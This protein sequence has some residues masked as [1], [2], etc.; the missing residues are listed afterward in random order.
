MKSRRIFK[1][2]N[3]FFQYVYDI[4]KLNILFLLYVFRGLVLFGLFP[5]FVSLLNCTRLEFYKKRE[6][7][8]KELFKETYKRDFKQA[9]LV[10]WALMFFGVILYAN[11]RV[12][13]SA[14]EEMPFFIVF[15]FYSLI[16]LYL[17]IGLWVFPLM[18]YHYNTVKQH[19][20][21]ALV[22]G[23]TNLT[24]TLILLLAVFLVFYISL[25]VP[26]FLLFFTASLLSLICLRM[27]KIPILTI[28]VNA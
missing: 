21:N 8:L 3:H 10:G 12:M 14:N 23:I 7:S 5:A 25:A 1:G 6:E 17:T 18:S 26:A 11:F 22:L 27:T 28:K 24:K 13:Q 4:A 20:V 19:I 16:F 9:N 15:S 2:F